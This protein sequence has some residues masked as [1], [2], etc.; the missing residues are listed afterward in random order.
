M[1]VPCRVCVAEFAVAENDT[2]PLP[3][4]LALP[5]TLN[6]LDALLTALHVQPAGAVTAVDPVPPPVATD[7]LT[8]DSEIVQATP[9]WLTVNVWPPIVRVPCRV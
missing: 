1:T 2:E 6:Q 5:V 7:A 4:P 9:V 3:L 8:G